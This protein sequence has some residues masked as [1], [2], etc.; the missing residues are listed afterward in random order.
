MWTIGMTPATGAFYSKSE[1]RRGKIPAPGTR[2]AVGGGGDTKEYIVVKLP[3]GTYTSGMA[4]TIDGDGTAV[5]GTTPPGVTIGGRLGILAL[6]DSNTTTIAS[7]TVTATTT[8]F[9]WAQIYGKVLA[10]TS[11]AVATPNVGL[12]LG[13]NGTLQ[14]LATTSVSAAVI[15][16]HALA[17]AAGSTLL[18]CFLN[19]PKFAAGAG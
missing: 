16:I 5:L 14:T 1:L 8:G 18:S 19:Y 7:S 2:G 4:V 11:G 15:G 6:K 3:A 17:T 9:C 10:L 13:A 12:S